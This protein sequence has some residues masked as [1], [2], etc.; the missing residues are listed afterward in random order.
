MSSGQLATVVRHLR[1][2]VE[3]EEA[4]GGSDAELVGRFVSQRDAAA[5]ELLVRRHERLVLGVCRRVL[6]NFHDAE[7]AFQAAFLVFARKAASVGKRQSLGPWLYRVAY[8]VA[9]RLRAQVAGRKSQSLPEADPPAA[10]AADPAASAAWRELRPLLDQEVHGLPARYHAPVVLCYLEGKSYDE[11][12]R[13]LGCSRGTVATRLNRARTLL[14]RRLERRGLVLT[15]GLLTILIAGEA[16][17]AGAPAARV[18]ATAQAAVAVAAG[19]PAAGLVAPHVSALTEGVLRTMFWT[20][21]KVVTA[22]VLAAL[23]VGGVGT[24][25]LRYHLARAGDGPRGTEAADQAPG[26]EA[27]RVAKAPA[28][29]APRGKSQAAPAAAAAPVLERTLQVRERLARPVEFNGFEPD[30]KMTLQEALDTLAREHDLQFDLDEAGF[31]EEEVTDVGNAPVAEKPLPAMKGVP[32]QV[33]LRKI[34]SRIPAKTPLTYVVR[35]NL[36][37]ITTESRLHAEFWPKDYRGPYFPLVT[38]KFDKRPVREALQELA[39]DAERSIVL[40]ERAGEA[41]QTPVTANLVNVPLDTAVQTL[42]DAADLALVPR[43]NL[44]YITTRQHAAELEK[45]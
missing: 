28:P 8:R 45:R 1:R 18:K 27:D 2:L 32:L 44:L 30:P 5:F 9:L 41:A 42:A 25:T 29:E 39:A 34:L 23:V 26:G 3:A 43:G 16:A 35:G 37:Q 7:D 33:V 40:D 14:R 11:A 21:L 36:I 19:A 15:A 12:A 31:K 13:Q 17:T 20:K 24:G 10:V 22:L 38:A 6:G 4:D